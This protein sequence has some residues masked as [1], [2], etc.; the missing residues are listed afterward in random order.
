MTA[1]HRPT[2]SRILRWWFLAIGGASVCAAIIAAAGGGTAIRTVLSAIAMGTPLLATV[3][4]D[5]LDPHPGAPLQWKPVLSRWWLVGSAAGLALA[6]LTLGIGALLPGATFDPTMAAFLDQLATTLPA[7]QVDAVRAQLDA[8][9]VHP[10]LLTIPQALIAGATL[11]ALFAFGEEIG[12]RGWLHR[13]LAP[14][15]FWASSGI[16]GLLWGL[17]HA[18]LILV[19]HNYPTQPLP[20]ILLFTLV[21]LGMSPLHAWVRERGHNVWAAAVLHGTINATAGLSALVVVG[22]E[23]LVGVPGVAGLTA[24]AVLTAAVAFARRRTPTES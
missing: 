16:T 4:M 23:L 14:L 22:S 24:G 5:R 3:A 11:N 9:P 6:L 19:G 7:D 1:S 13:E 15:G 2:A 8:M 12:W 18:P 20:G 21:C 17:W 10:V